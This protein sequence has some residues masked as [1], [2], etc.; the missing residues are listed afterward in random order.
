MAPASD[1]AHAQE[2]A[3]VKDS[4]AGSSGSS[5]IVTGDARTSAA[6][7]LLALGARQVQGSPVGSAHLTVRLER[8]P[9]TF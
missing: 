7:R 5:R 3:R 2:R 4:L 6:D 8:D 1:G 9:S